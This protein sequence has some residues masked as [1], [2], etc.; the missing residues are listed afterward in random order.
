MI[1]TF[2]ASA[3][4]AFTASADA[5]RSGTMPDFTDATWFN[6]P[7]ISAEDMEGHAVMVE[8]FRTW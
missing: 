4:L 1:T 8:V 6:T 5:Q 7:P 3:A 2:V